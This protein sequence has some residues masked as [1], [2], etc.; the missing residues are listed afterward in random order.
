MK[1]S[2]NWLKDYVQITQTAQQL[3]AMLSNMGFPTESIETIGD[4]TVIDLEITSNRGDCLCH[5]GIAREIAAATGQELKLPDVKFEMTTKKDINSLVAVEIAAPQFCGRYNARVIE[6]VKVGPSPEWMVKRLQAVGL[7]SVNNVVDATNYAMFETGQ[8]PHAFDYD[9]I[10]G[11]K[12]IV[13]SAK[14][15]EKIVSIDGTECE[16]SPQIL[17][18]A[19][20]QRPVAIAGVMGG[21]ETEV[22]DSTVNI[23]LEEASFNPLCV[24]GTSRKLSLPS[25]AAYRF[26]RIVNIENIEL[27]S[28]RTAQLIVDA[29][30]GKIV[31][32]S[33]DVYPGRPEQK[34]VELRPDRLNKLLGIDVPVQKA[35]DILAALKFEPRQTEAG[36]IICTVPNWRADVSREADLIEEVARVYGYDKVGVKEKISIKIAPVDKRQKLTCTVSNYLNGCGFYEAITTTFNDEKAARLLT[37]KDAKAS[38]AVQDITRKSENLLRS[39]LLGSLL[40]VVRTNL[41]AGGKD[42]RMYEIADVFKLLDDGGHTE[43][44]NISIVCSSDFGILKGAVAGLLKSIYPN[45]EIIFKPAEA[46]WAQAGAEIIL[47]SK[48]IGIAGVMSD[49]VVAGFDIKAAKICAAE[50]DFDSLLAMESAQIK[51]SPLPKFPAIV[52]DLSLIVD[53]Q[54]RWENLEQTIRSKAPQELEEIKLEGIYRGKPIAAGKK[55]VTVSLRFRDED[56][57]LKHDIVDGWEN[58]IVSALAGNVG[59]ELRKA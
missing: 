51:A 53:E 52:R 5:I 42:V 9:K 50:L 8:P 49:K 54:I 30:G 41:N 25:D 15:G 3:S 57:T 32:G 23:L 14:A 17:V 27:A 45:A 19:D 24:R 56:G 44:T 35:I 40:G 26:E 18:I 20:A 38:L 16:L 1:I 39:T 31:E 37:G 2:I 36:K 11:K 59:A 58:S 21:I 22:S 13:R 48:P 6:G 29:A 47:N 10:K 33:V 34:T 43:N 7:R 28:Q 46:Y 4:D 12:I 55:S